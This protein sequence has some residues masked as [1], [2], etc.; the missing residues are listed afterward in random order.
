M[1]QRDPGHPGPAQGDQTASAQKL[2]LERMMAKP[3]KQSYSNI[4]YKYTFKSN[5]QIICRVLRG[6]KDVGCSITKETD[7]GFQIHKVLKILN[8]QRPHQSHCLKPSFFRVNSSF[9]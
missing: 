7:S 5:Y 1:I 9:S 6:R 4:R 3:Y 2:I 8:L